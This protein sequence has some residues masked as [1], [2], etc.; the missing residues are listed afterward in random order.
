MS[1]PRL[2]LEKCTHNNDIWKIDE[3]Q[4][5]HLV[6]VRRCYTGSIVEGLLEGEKIELKLICES[7]VVYGQE[8][9]R[10][11][12]VPLS[13]EIHLVLGLLKKDQ[14]SQALRFCAETGVH[15]IHLLDCKR[16]I[17][18]YSARK[19]DDKMERWNKIL[20]EA[21]KQ[22]GSTIPPKL[23]APVK[24]KDF[25]FGILP[26]EKYAA[27]LAE[28][29]KELKDIEIPD[30]LAIAIGPEGDWDPSEVDVLRDNGFQPVSLGKRILRASTAVAVACGSISL[31]R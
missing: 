22:A 29:T 25:D 16:S 27:L 17:P 18:S 24:V 8:L 23:R 26:E 2:R 5:H 10:I 28:N 15:T 20:M 9:S 14:F 30:R 7:D 1:Q 6:H 19:L 3:E 4:A 31:M 11:K 13:T 21:T 12:E